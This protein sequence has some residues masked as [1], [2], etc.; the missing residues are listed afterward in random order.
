MS[1]VGPWLKVGQADPKP[2]VLEVAIA[3]DVLPWGGGE[4]NEDPSARLA[5]GAA[6]NFVPEQ[7]S[8]ITISTST[9][10][11]G[12]LEFKETASSI[13]CL[14]LHINVKDSESG[15]L[16]ME[17]IDSEG[18]VYVASSCF[19]TMQGQNK[20]LNRTLLS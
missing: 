17:F 8:K 11:F 16:P 3:P 1:Q 7:R 18:N 10:I 15:L 6:N 4:C 12:V 9:F 14:P 20:C 5:P 19:S 13:Q 2:T